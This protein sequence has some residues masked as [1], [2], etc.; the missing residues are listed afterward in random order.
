MNRII[1]PLAAA[2]LVVALAPAAASAAVTRWNV[3]AV[4]QG[5]YANAV[6]ATPD[7]QCAARYAERVSGLRAAFTSRRPIAY[8]TVAHAFTGPLRYRLSGRWSVTGAYVARR[9]QADGTLACAPAETPVACGAR[10]VFEDGH[11][12]STS[13]AARLAV[14]DNPSRR[15]VASRIAAPR[16]TE[17]YADAGRPP[18]GWPAVCTLSPD[19]EA[20]PATPMFGLSAT[21]VLDRALAARIRLPAARL[22]GR[23]RF[24][25]RTAPVH[26]GGCPAQGFDPCAEHGWARLRVTLSPAR[27]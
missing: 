20:L 10:V 17:Q 1:G 7:A 12:T 4:L 13:G 23:R 15:I 27:R 25:V 6:T 22:A 5:S 21:E 9:P 26:P 16:L 11:R 19:V 8:D 24:T 3:S 18:S 2:V 14:D